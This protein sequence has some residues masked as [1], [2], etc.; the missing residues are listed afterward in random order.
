MDLRW[1]LWCNQG[2]DLGMKGVQWSAAGACV[3]FLA[4]GQEGWPKPGGFIHCGET[5]WTCSSFAVCFGW[6]TTE[7]KIPVFLNVLRYVYKRFCLSQ[8][9]LPV[10]R[11]V[12]FGTTCAPFLT[13]PLASDSNIIFHPSIIDECYTDSEY[14]LCQWHY[15]PHVRPDARSKMRSAKWPL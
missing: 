13:L 8:P 10:N 14:L 12:S 4:P 11:S 3:S 15:T 2:S 9:C 7:I 6:C 5:S 1:V